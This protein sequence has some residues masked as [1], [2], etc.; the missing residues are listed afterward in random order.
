MAYSKILSGHLRRPAAKRQA[1]KPC[2]N[3]IGR[4][5]QTLRFSAGRANPARRSLTETFSMSK[6][7]VRAAW[8]LAWR[9][10]YENFIGRGGDVPAE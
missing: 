10:S 1:S 7:F 3:G 2:P 5:R 4:R 6:I 9:R 8:S